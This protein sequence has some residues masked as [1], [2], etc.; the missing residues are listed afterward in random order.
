MLKQYPF[1]PETNIKFSMENNGHVV[2]DIYNVKGQKVLT[3]LN[4]PVEKGEHSVVWKGLDENGRNVGSGVYFYQMKTDEY[5]SMKRM[6]L[7]K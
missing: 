5:T 3:L 4:R 6:V 2:I 1:N 7:M